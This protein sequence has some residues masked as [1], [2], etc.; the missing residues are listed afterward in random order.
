VQQFVAN[1]PYEMER[2]AVLP[3]SVR[4]GDEFAAHAPV[5][6]TG[7]RLTA[8]ASKFDDALDWLQEVRRGGRG[9]CCDDD[10]A[11]MCGA[12]RPV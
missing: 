6:R 7:E 3:V 2:C 12:P 8:G 1:A 9:C 11:D 4:S 5:G 10:H